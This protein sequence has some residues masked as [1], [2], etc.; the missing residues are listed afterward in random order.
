MKTLDAIVSVLLFSNPCNTSIDNTIS[1]NICPTMAGTETVYECPKGCYHED[2]GDS[3]YCGEVEIR[4]L[5]ADTPEIVHYEDGIF[6]NQDYGLA[7]ASFTYQA[8][9]E[10]QHI[11]IKEGEI[12]KYGRVLAHVEID[13]EL[14]SVRLIKAGLAYETISTYGDQGFLEFADQIMTASW[15]APQQKF[16]NPHDW[17]K[18]HQVK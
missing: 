6:I 13:N 17:R 15:T 3:F 9:T 11:I 4:L 14:L 10:A 2:D 12:D 1:A 7:A 16:Q 5:G 8:I 18:E